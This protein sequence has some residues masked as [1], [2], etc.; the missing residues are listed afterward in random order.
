MGEIACLDKLILYATKKEGTGHIHAG[1]CVRLYSEIN[2]QTGAELLKKIK[3]T[4]DLQV[5]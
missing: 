3:K 4:P 2:K 5:K 1:V